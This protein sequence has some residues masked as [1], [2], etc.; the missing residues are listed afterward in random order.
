MA[1][2]PGE[3]TVD[4]GLVVL[5]YASAAESLGCQVL[6]E[7]EVLSAFKRGAWHLQLKDH[8]V[9]AEHVVNCTGLG[10][11]AFAALSFKPRRG[12]QLEVRGIRNE[13]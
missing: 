10:A 12:E 13:R 2:R 7:Q 5:A 3:V 1:L 6:E 9:K 4:P 11:G 8:E